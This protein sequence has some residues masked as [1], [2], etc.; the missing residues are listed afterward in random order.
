LGSVASDAAVKV[1]VKRPVKAGA[2]RR[3]RLA[4]EFVPPQL[5]GAMEPL[6]ERYNQVHG[7]ALALRTGPGE[8]GGNRS[9][10]L[11]MAADEAMAEA[12]H[13]ASLADAY[14]ESARPHLERIGQLTDMLAQLAERSQRLSFDSL[15]F[16]PQQRPLSILRAALEDLQIEES[17]RVELSQGGPQQ[18]PSGGVL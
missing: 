5:Y 1:D 14:P 12:L 11:A 10:M 3:R 4:R 9:R 18:G 17:A 15:E 13:L 2:S 7:V 6:A 16:S 8:Q